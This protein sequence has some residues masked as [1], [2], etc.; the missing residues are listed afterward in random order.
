MSKRI[1]KLTILVIILAM[2]FPATALGDSHIVNATLLHTND[3]HGRLETDYRGRGGS[4]YIAS[5][6]NHIR[7]AVGEQN[8][9]LL[10]AGDV[11]FAAPAISQLLMGE[12]TIDIYNMMGYDLAAFGNHEFDKGQTELAARVAQSNF[13]WLGANVVLEGT[14]GE[15]GIGSGVVAESPVT[16]VARPAGADVGADDRDPVDRLRRQPDARPRVG[17][18]GADRGDDAGALRAVVEKHVHSG[19]PELVVAVA[20][21]HGLGEAPGDAHELVPLCRL[22]DKLHTLPSP[23]RVRR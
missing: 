21:G 20:G 12:S 22:G 13:P 14:E 8:V 10:D 7:S 18:A 17:V 1:F 11:Y 2:I 16:T 19:C 9:A 3:F 4:A 6:V 5:V 15:M 23:Q